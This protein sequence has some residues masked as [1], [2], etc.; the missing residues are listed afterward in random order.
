MSKEIVEVKENR[1]AKRG[2]YH[3]KP[4]TIDDGQNHEHAV[5]S[6]AARL[7]ERRVNGCGGNIILYLHHAL[8][9]VTQSAN[10][11]M[12][13]FNFLLFIKT[14]LKFL[15]TLLHSYT[16]SQALSEQSSTHVTRHAA[17]SPV[18]I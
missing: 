1:S 9:K 12:H 2:V 11:H 8:N 16:H 14:Y 13:T 4:K 7:Y 6:L 10:Q 17:T 3:C 5:Q 18:L 15:K